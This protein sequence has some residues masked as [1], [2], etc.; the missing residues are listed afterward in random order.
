[1]T[2]GENRQQSVIPSTSVREYFQQS[3]T[4]AMASRKVEATDDTVTY[5]VEMLAGFT[6]ADDLF[7]ETPDGVRIRPLALFYA[8]AVEAQT[9]SEKTNSLKRLG[10]VSLFVAGIFSDSL[11][12]KVV[13]LDYY[14]A[15]GGNAYSA[16]SDHVHGTVRGRVFCDIFSELAVKFQGFV[17]VLGELTE[18][19]HL[20]SDVD[21]LRLYEVWA[22]TGS[23]R[24]AEKLRSVG[25][26]PSIASVSRSHH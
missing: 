22:R 1:M 10:D 16:L 3:V 4:S 19:T 5:V 24:A 6:R 25:I 26:H 7:E 20:R 15:M 9:H 13:D 17:E 2:F 23:E 18:H 21:V 14:I 12:R 8:D 11:K